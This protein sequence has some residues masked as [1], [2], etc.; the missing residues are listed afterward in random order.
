MILH[1][2]SLVTLTAIPI[3]SSDDEYGELQCIH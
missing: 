3:T 1:K 2:L